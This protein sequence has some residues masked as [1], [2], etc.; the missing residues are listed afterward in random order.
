[1]MVHASVS[2]KLAQYLK[3]Q[4]IAPTQ[5]FTEIIRHGACL[6]TSDVVHESF[7]GTLNNT[8]CGGTHYYHEPN[9]LLAQLL[10]NTLDRKSYGVTTISRLLKII[11]LCCKKALY[12]RLYSAKE[13]YNFK[14]TTN[15]THPI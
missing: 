15:G 5:V 10:L 13:T 7:A 8:S 2:N 6:N 12:K 11:G 9:I 1:M 4:G 14:E 3:T